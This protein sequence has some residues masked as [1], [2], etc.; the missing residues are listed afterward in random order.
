MNFRIDITDKYYIIIHSAFIENHLA[1]SI[2]SY[3]ARSML[4]KYIAFGIMFVNLSRM[5]T[6]GYEKETK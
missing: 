3:W 5:V 2:N 4:N 6:F 1:L